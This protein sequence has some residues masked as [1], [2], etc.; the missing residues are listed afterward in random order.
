M[1]EILIYRPAL[2]GIMLCLLHSRIIQYYILVGKLKQ[3][4]QLYGYKVDK[5]CATCWYVYVRMCTRIYVITY[6]YYY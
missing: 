4:D 1:I 3:G 6:Y 2:A 5:V